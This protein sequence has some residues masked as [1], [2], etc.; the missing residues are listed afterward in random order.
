MLAQTTVFTRR[1]GDHMGPR[2][3]VA[4]ANESCREVVARLR[5]GGASVVI[6]EDSSERA[7]GIVTEQD[8]SRRIACGDRDDAPVESVMSAP[9][10]TISEND[11]LYRAIARMRRRGLRHMPVTDDRDRIVGVLELHEAMAVAAEHMLGHVDRLSH[12]DDLHGMKATKEAQMQVALELMDDALPGPEIQALL[13]RMNNDLYR[14]VVRLCLREMVSSGL[15]GPPADFDVVVM[16]SGGRGESFLR[17]DQ[18]N[19]F[20]IEDYPEAEHDRIDGWFI[21]LAMRVTDALAEVGFEYCNGHVMATNPLWRKTLSEWREQTRIWMGRSQGLALRYCDIFFDFSCVFG[22]GS[23]TEQLRTHVSALAPH[24]FFLRELFKVDEEHGV[25]LGLFD[26]LKRDPL[27]GPNQGQLNLKLTGTMPLVGAVRILALRERIRETG[28]LDR[29]AGLHGSGVL[30]DDEHDYLA[31]A[32]RHISRLLLRQQLESYRVG[33]A[34][35]NHVP[36]EALSEREKDMLVDAFKA[37]RGFRSRVRH[38]LLA[39]FL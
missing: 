12:E 30:D 26:R 33:Q 19:G 16:G 28:T 14:G 7:V 10:S 25:A 22:A 32:Y 1:V 17:P 18:D 3:L 11:Y 4:A 20:V 21:E 6:V 9:V 34:P 23:L 39:D 37:I 38:E 13:S 31:G 8:V 5:E 29:M 35:G 27:P 24:P 36:L 15:G 2:P